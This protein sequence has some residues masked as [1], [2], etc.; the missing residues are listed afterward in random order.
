MVTLTRWNP[1]QETVTLRDAVD[2]L[3]TD[4]FIRSWGTID[5]SLENTMPTDM[6]VD[7]DQIVVK[8]CLPGIKPNDVN[9]QVQ[10]NVLTITGELKE[11]DNR[12]GKNGQRW[13]MHERRDMRFVRSM[14]LPFAIQAD[15]TEATMEDGVLTL[16][17]PKLAPAYE[18]II[19]VKTK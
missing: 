1:M 5:Q 11:G 8:T 7:K 12:L 18:E 2:R 17:L 15:K 13:Y 6:Y 10:D 14:R 3:Y 9:I 19:P 16:E 4:S